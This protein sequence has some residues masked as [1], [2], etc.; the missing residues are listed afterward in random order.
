MNLY[1]DASMKKVLAAESSIRAYITKKK[2]VSIISAVCISFIMVGVAVIGYSYMVNNN[3]PFKPKI[4]AR[5]TSFK[6]TGYNNPVG[7]VWN[8]NFVLNYTNFGSE[9]IE[10]LTLTFTTNSTYQ[11]ERELSI[12]DPVP[13]HYYVAGSTMG[14]PIVVESLKAGETKVFYGE[15]WNNLEDSSKLSGFAIIATLKFQDMILDQAFVYP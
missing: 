3:N 9:L 14:Q 2:T 8:P 6:I 10:N 15:V 5:I 4:D 11:M 12:F 7:V 1:D 13:P